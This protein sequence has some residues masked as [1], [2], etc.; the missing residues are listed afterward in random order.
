[1]LIKEIEVTRIYI[2]FGYFLEW[3][4]SVDGGRA[5]S[6]L[7]EIWI[8][9]DSLEYKTFVLQCDMSDSAKVDKWVLLQN[10][11]PYAICEFNSHFDF[12]SS[13]FVGL[14]GCGE[15]EVEY[16]LKRYYLDDDYYIDEDEL[17]LYDEHGASN[18]WFGKIGCVVKGFVCICD[19]SECALEDLDEDLDDALDEFAKIGKEVYVD[20]FE[21]SFDD[22]DIDT[23]KM[24]E[25]VEDL[26]IYYNLGGKSDENSLI[27]DDLDDVIR[28][29]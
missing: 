20:V 22:W 19:T 3:Y 2:A 7:S 1:M 18:I 8:G 14:D 25:S 9:N 24:L 17:D 29:N 26:G 12:T 16:K 11:F 28:F 21:E 6:G 23:M 15:R 10:V 27:E 4:Q 13:D 5:S